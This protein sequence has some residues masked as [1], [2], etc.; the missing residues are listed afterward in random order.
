MAEANFQPF[1]GAFAGPLGRARGAKAEL[2]DLGQELGA[3]RDGDLG[4]GGG[5]RRSH[6]GGEVAERR[7]RLVADGGYDRDRRAGDGAND[8]LLVERPQ[9]LDRSEE[10]TSELQSLMRT[11]IA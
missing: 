7:V 3:N 10:H 4:G 1:G 6:V 11:S 5:S 9:I 8:F 2:A